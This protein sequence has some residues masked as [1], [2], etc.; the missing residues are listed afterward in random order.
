[1][2]N[3]YVYDIKERIEAVFGNGTLV[4]A[5]GHT[6]DGEGVFE[7]GPNDKPG[8]LGELRDDYPMETKGVI[9]LTFK[10]IDAVERMISDLEDLK[11]ILK[12]YEDNKEDD[13]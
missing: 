5:Y 2:I 4:T 8:E 10:N 12:E 6:D 13:K 7:I 3:H 11:W 1:M 9:R